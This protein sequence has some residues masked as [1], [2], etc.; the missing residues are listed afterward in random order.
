MAGPKVRPPGPPKFAPPAA[1][2]A[3]VPS[4]NAPTP[5]AARAA[6]PS[7][8]PT[9]MNGANHALASKKVAFAGAATDTSAG[10]AT[11]GTGAPTRE[12]VAEAPLPSAPGRAEPNQKLR[13]VPL[14]SMA[15]CRS[16]Q[17]EDALKLQVIAAV[18]NRKECSSDAGTY[19]FVETKN[20]N[21]FLLWIER[22]PGRPAVDRCGELGFALTCLKQ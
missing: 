4:D 3:A 10:T 22:A 17:R 18:R 15:A 19:R 6:A 7:P 14:S 20:L 8:L 21:A 9:A 5:P 11:R 12:R 1:L 13:G 16:D 2:A